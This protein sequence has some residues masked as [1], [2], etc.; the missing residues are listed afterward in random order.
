MGWLSFPSLLGMAIAAAF[1]VV[2]TR[3]LARG[4]AWYA[5]LGAV[6]F[7]EVGA[8]S[9]ND[10]VQGLPLAEVLGVV[11][12]AVWLLQQ[13]WWPIGKIRGFEGVL[14]LLLPA[15][16]LSLASGMVF[17]DRDV[18]QQNVKLSVSIGQ[19]LLF[20]WPMAVYFVT[21]RIVERGLPI[22]RWWKPTLW[23]AVPQV[24]LL[25]VPASRPYVSWSIYFGLIAAPLAFARATYERDWRRA[26]GYCLFGVPLFLEGLWTGKAFLYG[27]VLIAFAAVAALRARRMLWLALP[28]IGLAASMVML[29]PEDTALPGPLAGL[30]E[31]E[32]SQ[33][34]WGGEAGRGQLM[35]DALNIW[36]RYPILGVGPA[37]CYPYMLRY[38][39]LGTPHSQYADLILECG[40]IG[41][42]IFLL[43][44][45]GAWRTGFIALKQ[46]GDTERDIFLVGWLASF[47]ALAVVS[48][49]GDYMMH[50]IRNGG[51]GMFAGFYLQ[52]IFLG[53]AM[54]LIRREQTAT[55][56][57]EPTL[58]LAWQPDS[59]RAISE[60][61]P[62]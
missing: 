6:P 62:R 2:A 27:Y 9:G 15:S 14:L 49:T 17:L 61:E 25:A 34:S 23:M 20:A 33:Q 30:V 22:E 48:I 32:R 29:L 13:S 11:L 45:A 44:I 40:V 18:P 55:A 54:G 59:V 1:A 42:G 31:Q 43:F 46:V 28:A 60:G 50:S 10:L 21:S 57:A 19:I 3:N 5:V 26:I 38:S 39:I 51:I 24:V 7:I 16:V 53:A 12:L 58:R 41:L 37:N 36:V 4:L 47:T 56:A 52:W 8:F 35:E